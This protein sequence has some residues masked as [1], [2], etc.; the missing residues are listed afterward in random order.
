MQE[1]H[2]FKKYQHCKKFNI[3]AIGHKFWQNNIVN[4]TPSPQQK[5]EHLKISVEKKVHILTASWEFHD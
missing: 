1:N 4:E 2:T 5:T 3:L